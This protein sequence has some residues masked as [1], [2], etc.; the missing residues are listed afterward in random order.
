M[1]ALIC[2]A[3]EISVMN[4]GIVECMNT[5]TYFSPRSTAA[6]IASSQG[7]LK[8]GFFPVYTVYIQQPNE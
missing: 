1:A 3:I 4:M 5:S 6:T 8:Y 7:K 2:M